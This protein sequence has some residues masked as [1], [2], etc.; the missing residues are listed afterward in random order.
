MAPWGDTKL[1]FCILFI[2]CCCCSTDTHGLLLECQ[3]QSI[4]RRIAVDYR[5][6]ISGHG[7][8]IDAMILVARAGRK[9]CVPADEPWVQRV[10]KHVEDLKRFCKKQ[11]YKLTPGQPVWITDTK[12]Q[13]TVVSSHSA[14][15][16]Y[17]VDGPSGT[18]RR[19]RHHLVPF[20]ETVPHTPHTP[21]PSTPP[22]PGEPT[23]G[24]PERPESPKQ[25]PKGHTPALHGAQGAQQPVWVSLAQDPQDVSF[26]EAQLSRLG[27]DVVTQRSYFTEG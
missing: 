3:S 24:S 6:Q 11:Q 9:L 27:G 14:P 7:C 5:R 21:T 2:T 16:S 1:F 12:S 25:T 20:P 10:V 18:I 19:N 15:R 26:V 23:L 17:I 4:D 22:Q 13:G 8:S